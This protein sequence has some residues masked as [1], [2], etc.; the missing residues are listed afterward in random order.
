[1]FT[2]L[3]AVAS[4][5]D[6]AGRFPWWYLQPFK[7]PLKSVLELMIFV[8]SNHW[9]KVS[10]ASTI[11]AQIVIFS[12]CLSP[13][14]NILDIQNSTLMNKLV[15]EDSMRVSSQSSIV[16]ECISNLITHF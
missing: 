11:R 9:K 13:N 12:L 7:I 2:I 5:Q 3:N 6:N 14:L 10:K 8:Y 16:L 1:V 15:I 4:F